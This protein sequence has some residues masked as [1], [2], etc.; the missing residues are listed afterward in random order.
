MFTE[1]STLAD[2]AE[3]ER[4]NRISIAFRPPF[5]NSRRWT[6][7]IRALTKSPTV[8]ASVGRGKDMWDALN[9]AVE[10]YEK[11]RTK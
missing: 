10:Q 7:V 8:Y 2:V 6:A 3:Y 4:K 9:A 11:D 1:K 5:H